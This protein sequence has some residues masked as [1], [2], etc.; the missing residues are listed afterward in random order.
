MTAAYRWC[1]LYVDTDDRAT[2]VEHAGRLLGGAPV[3]DVF[4]L[5]GFTVDVRGNPDRTVS[6]HFLDWRTMVDITA[7]AR[8]PDRDVVE[9]VTVLMLHL[10]AGGHR[11]AADCDFAD[12][13][14]PPDTR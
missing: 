5:P 10:R 9:F 7:G 1:S 11:V 6:D 8:I 12:R 13:L 2:V 14:P 4:T 3:D